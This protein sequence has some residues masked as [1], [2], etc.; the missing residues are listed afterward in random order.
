MKYKWK[1][2]NRNS[3]RQVLLDLIG[4]G[5]GDDAAVAELKSTIEHSPDPDGLRH[6]VVAL[7]DIVLTSDNIAAITWAVKTLELD[8]PSD[9]GQEKA[10]EQRALALALLAVGA[11]GNYPVLA[12]AISSF[13]FR[14][15]SYDASESGRLSRRCCRSWTTIL[16]RR[17]QIPIIRLLP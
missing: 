16:T 6:N 8:F 7:V 14:R 17:A 4:S 1:K 2:I 9:P 13:V 10:L 15:V 12:E 5:K 11:T 3:D